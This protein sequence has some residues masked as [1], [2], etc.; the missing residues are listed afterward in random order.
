MPELRHDPIQRRW[1][2]I[3]AERGRRPADF[4]PRR[5]EP[6][7]KF[8]P[9]C[10]GHEEKTPA[11]I[12]VYGAKGP[13]GANDPWL[14]RVM[15]NKFPA[16]MVEGELDRLAYGPYDYMNGV[17]AHEVIVETPDHGQQLPDLSLDHL[18]L[19]LD[20]YRERLDDLLRDTR[21]RY[22]MIFKNYGRL[23]GATVSHPHSQVIATPVTPRTLSSELR[24]AM[25]HY[26]LKERC[27]YCDV[28]AQELAEGVRVVAEN[29]HF[30]AYCP[31]AS[32]VPF[33]VH[34]FPR[35]HAADFRHT[36]KNRLLPLAAILRELLARMRLALDDPPYNLLFHTAPNR[37]S[38]AKRAG[39]WSTLDFDFHWHIEIFPRLTQVAGF[40]W[41]T[42]FYI[43][44][45]APETAAQFLREVQPGGGA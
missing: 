43:N 12:R 16:L 2:I 26:H 25:D 10:P 15:P 21:L 35:R 39:Y 42:G 19:L 11:P 4:M 8:C 31:Y 44:P 17:G 5:E 6:E 30:V 9:F 32:R 20:V 1:V 45:T 40:E 7:P 28:L 27:L 3:A 29:E 33:E 36:G 23:A 38:G 37:D 13:V 18:A 41:G 22:V 14:V 24:S 34:V